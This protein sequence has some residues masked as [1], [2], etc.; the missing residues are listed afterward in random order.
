MTLAHLA[1]RSFAYPHRGILMGRWCATVLLAALAMAAPSLADAQADESQYRWGEAATV[2]TAGGKV[3]GFVRNGAL[4]FRGIP[5]GASVAGDNRWEMPKPA[6][7]W[8]GV[9]PAMHFKGTCAQA[10]RYGLT[11]RSDN[12]D[13]LTLNV[14][15]PYTGENATKT[16]RPV[17]VWIH[18]GAFVGGASSL[19]RLDQLA[20]KA[21]AV[22]VTMNYR[23]GVFGFMPHPAFGADR[24]GGYALEDQRLAL[25]WVKDNIAAFGGDPDNIT[26]A[27]ESA[28]AASVCMHLIAPEETSG[29]FHKAIVQSGACVFRLRSVED[30][31]RFGETVAKN[32]GCA[33]PT[34]ALQ[35]LR[36]KD[37]QTLIAAG[38]AAGGADLMAFA[39][40]YG[41]KTVPR[42]GLDALESG[43][44]VQVP[45]L[46]GGTRD[47]LRLYVGYDVQAGKRYTAEN[48]PAAIKAIY[49][50]NADAVIKQYPVG[51]FASAPVALGTVMSDFRP[52][53]GINH[54]L[55][56]EAA[57]L[58][59]R[60]VPV[61]QWE[62]ADRETPVLGVAMPIQPDTGF[63]L[64]A[65]HSSELNA[66]FPN[67][68]NT[69]AISGPDLSARSQAMAEQMIA[70]WASFIRSGRPAAEGVPA[71][72][73]YAEGASSIRFEPGNVHAFDASS[74]HKCAFWKSL[75]PDYFAK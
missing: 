46:N 20:K 28:G 63:P 72:K 66:F 21:D 18:G 73:P 57:R 49:G 36:G 7:A 41:T 35:C 10:A 22:V 38:D 74:D 17:I 67:F 58:M 11:E 33:D 27:G 44:F 1:E 24:N 45:V 3:A 62:F 70:T 37:P 51:A 64:G 69:T 60:R 32:A 23:L 43:R 48:Y 9:L 40:S 75:Y 5:Y 31:K 53:L 39:P 68:S 26:V 15:L 65:A 19:Y 56:L 12:E 34:T 25:R 71:W 8:S 54:C 2:Q 4:E 16:K 30:R 52:D 61:Y 29:L 6:A 55:Y 42:Q 14:S 50:D 59:S 13:C 47:E